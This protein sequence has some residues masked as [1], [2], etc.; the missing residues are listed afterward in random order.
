MT[1]PRYQTGFA[2]RSLQLII[3]AGLILGG[4]LFYLTQPDDTTVQ[5]SQPLDSG[6]SLKSVIAGNAQV[7]NNSSV[8]PNESEDASSKP[9][10]RIARTSSSTFSGGSIQKSNTTDQSEGNYESKV[11]KSGEGYAVPE[12]NNLPSHQITARKLPPLN[13][14]DVS[15]VQFFKD[16]SNATD[17]IRGRVLLSSGE[18]AKGALVSA[19]LLNSSLN[20]NI[21]GQKLKKFIKTDSD[22][23]FELNALFPGRYRLKARINRRYSTRSVDVASGSE[24]VD[25]MLNQFRTVTLSGLIIDDKD[26]PVSNAELVFKPTGIKAVTDSEGTFNIST[27]IERNG[28]YHVEVEKEGFAK[29]SVSVTTARLLDVRE[30][31]QLQIRLKPAQGRTQVTGLV[32]DNSG[33]LLQAQKVSLY[34]PLSGSYSARTNRSGEFLIDD[35][36]LGGEYRLSVTPE[37]SYKR[38]LQEKINLSETSFFDVTLESTTEFGTLAGRVVDPVGNP[39]PSFTLRVG[40]V[41]GVSF[42]KTIRTNQQGSFQLADIPA[43]K[44]YIR[45]SGMPDL[46]LSNISLAAGEVKLIDIPLDWGNQNFSGVVATQKGEPLSGAKVQMQWSEK[47]AGNSLSRTIR[48]AYTDNKGQFAFSNL[49]YGKRSL[50]LSLLGYE[51]AKHVVDVTTEQLVQLSIGEKR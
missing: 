28:Q 3:A 34:S 30:G 1:C 51:S 19:Q 15:A 24:K 5:T 12:I 29:S 18:L 6:E 22:G 35:V 46:L 37:S 4:S 32:R 8:I 43:G 41:S 21:T 25:L 38:Y 23:R 26:W 2:S 49:G 48:T 16:D 13:S 9:Q 47:V 33:Q 17:S 31:S 50:N 44:F 20:K 45:S 36:L 39:V 42:N 14:E 40:S 11:E 10:A 7:F 27:E